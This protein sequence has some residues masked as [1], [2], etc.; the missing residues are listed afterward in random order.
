MQ[1][2]REISEITYHLSE[3]IYSKMTASDLSVYK[4]AKISKVT[5]MSIYNIINCRN[6]MN[7]GTA[8]EIINGLGFDFLDF[9][10]WHKARTKEKAAK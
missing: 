3:F 5:P 9:A 2:R 10:M 7:I 4:L 8:E 1:R 6:N